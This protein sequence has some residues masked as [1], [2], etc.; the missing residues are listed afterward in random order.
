M[1]RAILSLRISRRAIGAAV[2]SGDALT[3]TDG[4]HL[5][6]RRERSAAA[7]VRYVTRVLE[8][9]AASAVVC[10]VP[11]SAQTTV[12]QHVLRAVVDVLTARGLAPSLVTKSDVLAAYGLKPLPTRQ[13]VREV[14][15]EFW[16]TLESMTGRVKPYVADAAAAA[17]YAECRLALNP[18][19]T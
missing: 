1:T 15:S 13:Q 10:D 9:S 14:V 8:Q 6:S 5:S 19:P 2:L 16:P 18:P 7:A 11:T 12:S 17:L 3:L 4:R